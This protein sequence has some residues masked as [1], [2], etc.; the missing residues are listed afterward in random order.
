LLL[1]K[2]RQNT[3]SRELD[4][5]SLNYSQGIISLPANP[6]VVLGGFLSEKSALNASAHR[7]NCADARE[8]I[9]GFNRSDVR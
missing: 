5:L 4:I 1:Q 7:H 6:M 2:H 8:E 3:P 9:K